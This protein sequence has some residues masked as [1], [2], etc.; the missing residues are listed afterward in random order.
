MNSLM[1]FWTLTTIASLAGGV[2]SPALATKVPDAVS[3][4]VTAPVVGHEIKVD[5]VTYPVM[6]TGDTYNALSTLKIG[7]HVDLLLNAPPAS[8][9]AQVIRITTQPSARN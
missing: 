1:K 4:T 6:A 7:D 3:G 9:R 8:K 5:G 2:V